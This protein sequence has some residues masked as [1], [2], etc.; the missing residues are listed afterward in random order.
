ML[1]YSALS[2][3]YFHRLCNKFLFEQTYI[4]IYDRY[5]FAYYYRVDGPPCD[6]MV[7][8]DNDAACI[9]AIEILFFFHVTPYHF[10]CYDS[11]QWWEFHIDYI[12]CRNKTNNNKTLKTTKSQW[13][14]F[15]LDIVLNVCLSTFLYR[16]CHQN[17]LF[18]SF[19][20]LSE[21]HLQTHWKMPWNKRI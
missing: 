10:P 19:I 17:H 4:W 15:N 14:D 13:L 8:I 7:Q 5:R 11:K 6:S 18:G 9:Y 2:L 3:S 16:F 20:S 1:Y 12:K 21:I